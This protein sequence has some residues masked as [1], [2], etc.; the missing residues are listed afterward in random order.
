MTFNFDQYQ[1]LNA[2]CYL[3]LGNQRSGKYCLEFLI[4]SVR[5][6]TPPQKCC[7]H[8]CQVSTASHRRARAR[9]SW[10]ASA[11]SRPADLQRL[12]DRPAY[13]RDA[14]PSPTLSDTHLSPVSQPTA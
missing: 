2:I 5:I 1:I 7:A 11:P 12:G 10:S 9:V 14:T 6:V 13:R 4:G 8:L 3:T